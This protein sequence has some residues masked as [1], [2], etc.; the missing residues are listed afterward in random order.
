[1]T[2]R[3]PS[4]DWKGNPTSAIVRGKLYEPCQRGREWRLG[5]VQ[6]TSRHTRYRAGMT[7]AARLLDAV[8]RNVINAATP[9]CIA[10]LTW[11][12]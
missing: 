6:L 7:Q 9:A 8:A 1:M 2:V 4:A 10:R 3:W 12:S 5:A 11:T